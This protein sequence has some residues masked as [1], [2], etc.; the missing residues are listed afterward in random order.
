MGRRGHAGWYADGCVCTVSA[1]DASLPGL[2][3]SP[4][5][6]LPATL[7]FGSEPVTYDPSEHL[8]Q[9]DADGE[10]LKVAALPFT[11]APLN[12]L[13]WLSKLPRTDVS[14]YGLNLRSSLSHPSIPLH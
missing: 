3:L 7:S 14:K 10:D 12:F 2:S 13:P 8:H 6:N 9:T 5:N 1:T 4:L 11:L